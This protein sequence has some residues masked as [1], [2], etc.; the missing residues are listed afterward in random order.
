MARPLDSWTW[1]GIGVAAIA[2][3]AA[4][5]GAQ[6]DLAVAVGWGDLTA[7]LLPGCVD[8]LAAVAARVWLDT[9]A[10]DPARRYARTV[11]LTAVAA[12]LALNAGGHAM[13]AGLMAVS[14]PLVVAVG[15]VPA[16]SLAAT[17]HLTAARTAPVARRRR[18]RADLRTATDSKDATSSARP[19]TTDGGATRS[20]DRGSATA[21]G[22]NVTRL[23]RGA[24]ATE[25]AQRHWQHERANGRTPTGAELARVAGCSSSMGRR[26]AA[27]F[28]ATDT[29]TSAVTG[30]GTD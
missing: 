10:P 1:V 28:R 23:V 20:R 9:A 4:S 26:L 8:T 18:H 5:A 27:E 2:A 7:W 15:A 21:T 12:S 11:A 30:G 3:A 25:R 17:V 16:A 19:A 29:T 24:T 6:H 14:V 22:A 13:T